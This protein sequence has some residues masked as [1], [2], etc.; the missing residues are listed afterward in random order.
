M[1][2][3]RRSTTCR[4][5]KHGKSYVMS[6]PLQLVKALQIQEGDEIAIKLDENKN[7]IVERYLGEKDADAE[8]VHVRVIGG[9]QLSGGLYKQLGFTVPL[10]KAHKIVD[11]VFEFP[12]IV[13]KRGKYFKL[14]FKRIEREVRVPA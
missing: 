4:I 7:L 12:I 5:F 9:A 8:V 1:A 10:E 6:L 3:R 14:L 13:E 11:E 2:K